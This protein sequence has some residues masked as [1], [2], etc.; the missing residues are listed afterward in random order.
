MSMSL[1]EIE[2]AILSLVDEETGEILDI[3]GLAALQM[4]RERKIENVA[5]WVKNLTA[6]QEAIRN[7]EK[8]LADRRKVLE[9]RTDR[10][11]QYLNDALGGEKFE[12]A[13]CTVS[14]RKTSRVEIS[15]IHAA[16]AWADDNGLRDIVTYSLPTVSK[17]ELA[18]LLKEGRKIPGC[19]LIDGFSMSVR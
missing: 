19:T 14:F 18:K 1:Y 11:T 6:E 15:D 16:A 2:Q 3:E 5:C 10:L 7:E 9:R 17:P 12:T 4:E 8:R 13:R